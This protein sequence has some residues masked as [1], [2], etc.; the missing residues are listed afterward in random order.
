VIF[1]VVALLLVPVVELAVM[2]Q[3]GQ[4][5]GVWETI[6]LLLM[7]SFIGVWIV[8]QQGTGAWRRMRTDLAV[9]RVPGAALVDGG[10]LLAA[11]VLFI[12][13]GF[14]TDAL[15]ALLL[16]PP[17]RA[18]ARGALGRRFRVVASA[19]TGT[20]SSTVY[21]VGPRPSRR[22]EPRRDRP[23]SNPELGA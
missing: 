21:D 20:S 3:V 12:V 23:G 1:F 13:P 11:G 4:W 15:G 6:A 17:L 22:P 16:V 9:G 5:I 19:H 8:K 14:V 18:L 2:I 7:V 10:L